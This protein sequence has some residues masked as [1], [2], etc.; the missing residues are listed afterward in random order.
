M[1]V[2]IAVRIPNLPR[3][4]PV[5]DALRRMGRSVNPVDP[6]QLHVTLK[7]LGETPAEQAAALAQQLSTAIASQPDASGEVAGL[8][9]F[10]HAERPSVIWAGVKNAE[11]LTD[12]AERVDACCAEFGFPRETRAFAP[13]VTLARVKFRPPER[14][15]EMLGEESATRYGAFSADSVEVLE[16]VAGRG[17]PQYVTLSRTPL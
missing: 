14:L 17:G 11:W 3:L 12:L 9:A 5:F 7:F 2:F 8:G 16:S 6:N 13:H 4:A 1:R 10:P 15:R